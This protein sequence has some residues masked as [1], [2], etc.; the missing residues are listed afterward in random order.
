MLSFLL[1]LTLDHDYEFPARRGHDR[2]TN[3]LK[4]QSQRSVGPKARLQIKSTDGQTYKNNCNTFT[5]T[6]AEM[7]MLSTTSVE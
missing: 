2:P 5:V 1:N 3:M 7:T 4:N 6:Q